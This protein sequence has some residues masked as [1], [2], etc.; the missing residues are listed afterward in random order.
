MIYLFRI[1][2]LFIAV[3][4]CVALTIVTSIIT[5]IGCIF[6]N[7]RF[8][9]YYPAKI[10]AMIF[11]WLNF[12]T[13]S[14]KGRQNID[15]ATSYVFVANHQGAFDIFA[16]YGFLGHNFKWMMK[17]SLRKIPF[18]GYACY[19][20]GH[21]FV[22][23]TSPTAIRQS[24]KQAESRLSSGMSLVVFPEGSR[25]KTGRMGNFKRGAYILAEEFNLPVVPVTIDG[26]FAILPRNSR[27]PLPRPGHIRL[28]IHQPIVAAEG[29][30]DINDLMQQSREAIESG[31]GH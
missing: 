31:F 12:I 16:I 27:Y 20:A 7:G 2:Q 1:Y 5:I 30:H 6:S 14:V 9:G 26:A 21:I 24:L 3:P 29:G 18:V 10:W 25:T 8:W 17:A 28:T 11:C 19:K 22:D 13:V 15:S 4:L 23:R